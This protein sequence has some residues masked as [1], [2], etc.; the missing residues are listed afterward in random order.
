M[1]SN[2][3]SMGPAGLGRRP[4]L[5]AMG[6]A[7][8][9]LA[10]RGAPAA[11]RGA[12][13]LIVPYG[14]GGPT[15]THLRAVAEEAGK[16]LGQTLVIEN[17]PGA[18]GITGAVSLVR[19]APDGRTLAVLP[20]SVYR[21][22][23]VKAQPYD[24]A[25]SFS[26]VLLL[27]DYTFGL[28][29]RADRPWKDWK[30]F[31]AEAQKRPGQLNVGATGSAGTPRIVMDEVAELT[32]IQ[33]NII[34]FK[35]DAEVTNALLGGH[36]DAAPL[37]GVAAPHIEAGKLRYLAMLTPARTKRFP[38]VSTLKEQGVDAFIDSPYG[39]AAPAGLDPV[40]LRRLHDA[41]HAALLSAPSQRAMGAL[42]QSIN[43]L[44]PA[45]YRQYALASY[46][47]EKA[48]VAKL[49]EKGLLE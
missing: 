19:A 49:R 11:E 10:A 48:R 39:I 4:F 28:A 26:Y 44:D 38:D 23:Y 42:N 33:L 15:D 8:L 14:A 13:T 21:E 46:A 6:A 7:T 5:A 17:R 47:R 31:A 22:P 34:P 29:V 43:Y 40:E 2:N 35:G 12:I 1:S 32:K 3:K 36:I 20:A 41:F 9:G 24:V 45:A 16:L 37:S 18:N 25:K 27:S 30:D